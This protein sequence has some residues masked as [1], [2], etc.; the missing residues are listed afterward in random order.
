[1]NTQTIQL[2][3][4]GVEFE[5]EVEFS[6]IQGE[7][8]ITHLLPENCCEGS[9]DEYEL[10]SLCILI[11]DK[12]FPEEHDASFLIYDEDFKKVITQQLVDIK[13]EM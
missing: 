11:H 6:F 3:I 8:A 10:N 2:E 12:G 13:N 9:P 5:A 1:M 4:N 7:P